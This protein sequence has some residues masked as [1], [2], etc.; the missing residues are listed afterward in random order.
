MN[1]EGLTKLEYDE[2]ITPEDDIV[3]QPQ[4]MINIWYILFKCFGL[5]LF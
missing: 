5:G 2:V 4:G 1:G 3:A